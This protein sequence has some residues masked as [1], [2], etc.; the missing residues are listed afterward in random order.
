MKHDRKKWK[1]VCVLI[2]LLFAKQTKCTVD[3]GT[4]IKEYFISGFDTTQANG[5]DTV[6]KT[7]NNHTKKN[8]EHRSPANGDGKM[9]TI[10]LS[11]EKFTARVV[12]PRVLMLVLVCSTNHSLLYRSLSG[13]FK[14]GSNL[15]ELCSIITND[16]YIEY[17]DPHF[18]SL[19]L[20]PIY[21]F[22][23]PFS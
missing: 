9:I 19:S 10:T 20:S 5:G 8:D 22:C 3:M 21:L 7:D 2:W 18:L 14:Q 23:S 13:S 1:S 15:F 17:V 4:Q 11:T 6:N 12:A 16:I